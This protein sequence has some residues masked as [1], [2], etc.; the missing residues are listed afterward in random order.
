MC[1]IIFKFTKQWSYFSI[2]KHFYQNLISVLIT[3]Y[4]ETVEMQQRILFTGSAINLD[5]ALQLL[6]RTL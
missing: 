5:A 4:V 3:A 6:L 2:N 1:I